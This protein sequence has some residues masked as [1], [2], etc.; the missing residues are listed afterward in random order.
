MYDGEILLSDFDTLV[1]PKIYSRGEEYY[2]EGV[3]FDLH[4][5]SEGEWVVSVRGTEDYRVEIELK[6]GQIE[7]W[8]CDYPYDG[9]ICK[10]VVAVVLAIRE[11]REGFLTSGR[12]AE[13]RWDREVEEEERWQG[14]EDCPSRSM[15]VGVEMQGNGDDKV[16]RLLDVVGT[17][18]IR[19]FLSQ[20]AGTHPDFKAA[21]KEHFIPGPQEKCSSGEAVRDCFAIPGFWCNYEPALDWHEVEM[22]LVGWFKKA[23]FYITQGVFR[24]AADIALRILEEVGQNYEESEYNRE[25]IAEYICERAA[26]MLL[27]IAGHP[28]ADGGLKTEMI[29]RLQEI[30]SCSTFKEFDVYDLETFILKLRLLTENDPVAL[31]LLDEWIKDHPDNRQ[32]DGFVIARAEILLRLGRTKEA[33]EFVRKYVH[34][35]EVVAWEVE[36]LC[37][38]GYPERALDVL[39]DALQYARTRSQCDVQR[40]LEKKIEIYEQTGRIPELIAV[41]KEL[42]L[43]ESGEMEYYRKLKQYV[44]AGEWKATLDGL[45]CKLKSIRWFPAEPIA[46]IYLA[47]EDY[48][49]LLALLQHVRDER[50]ELLVRYASRL[51]EAYPQELLQLFT[52]KIREYAAQNVGRAHYKYI[53]G[54]LKKVR[55]FPGGAT[56]VSGLVGDFRLRYRCRPAMMQELRLFE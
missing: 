55:H 46:A 20:Y 3:V 14:D 26:G 36:R 32:L 48:E 4:E 53:A 27:D 25:S 11:N 54:L 16:A 45:L 44:P 51:K 10:H 2:E 21:L 29:G 52:T 31:D 39:D 19:R 30:A 23:S 12:K 7:S 18:E 6:G 35:P 22:Q 13:D 34:L 15:A 24:A 8:Y 42:F 33:E 50:L 43:S 38:A 40:Y 28:E 47:E 5:E 56:A 49:Q 37:K 1:P 17:V 41:A 9:T